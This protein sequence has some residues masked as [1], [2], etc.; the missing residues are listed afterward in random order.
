MASR[1]DFVTIDDQPT[2][3]SAITIH[4]SGNQIMDGLRR[5]AAI[6]RCGVFDAAWRRINIRSQQTMTAQSHPL[7]QHHAVTTANI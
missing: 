4:T 6:E 7:L 3:V 1:K 5:V 2:Y